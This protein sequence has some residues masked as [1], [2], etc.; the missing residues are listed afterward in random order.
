LAF[1]AIENGWEGIIVYGGRENPD[2]V[3]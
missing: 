3:F 1:K 2:L